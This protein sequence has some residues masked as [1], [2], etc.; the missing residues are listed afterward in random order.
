M[1]VTLCRELYEGSWA[2]FCQDLRDRL[3]GKPHVFETTPP[4]DYMKETIQRHL[5]LIDRLEKL[6]PADG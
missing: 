5:A 4:S 2:D 3:D 6:K 1:L